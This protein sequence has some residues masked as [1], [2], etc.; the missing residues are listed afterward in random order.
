LRLRA[1][2]N[3]VCTS[4]LNQYY[5]ALRL[6]YNPLTSHYISYRKIIFLFYVEERVLSFTKYVNLE[7]FYINFL[8]TQF[9]LI[10]LMFRIKEFLLENNFQ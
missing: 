10:M 6:I 3:Q 1:S 2:Q 8:I 7:L 9:I 5:F 4:G